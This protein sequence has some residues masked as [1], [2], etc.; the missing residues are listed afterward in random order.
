MSVEES[1][2]QYDSN[3]EEEDNKRKK[4][5]KKSK[6]KK[7]YSS[8]EENSNESND[9]ESKE[10]ESEENE[11]DEE[12]ESGDDEGYKKRKKKKKKK[13]SK[14]KK[15]KKSIINEKDE[16]IEEKEEIE[17]EKIRTK[18]DYIAQIEQLENE[19]LLEKKISD[20]LGENTEIN[21]ELLQLQTNLSE[22]TE[23]LNQLITTNH[24]QEEAL[25]VLRRQ[26]DK[27][28]DKYKSRN[29][30]KILL[31]QNFSNPIINNNLEKKRKIF[32]SQNDESKKEAINI[33]LKIK[34]KAI[35]VAINKMNM[36]KKENELLKKELYKNDDYTNKLGLEDNSNENKKKLLKLN[37][38]LK[39]LNSQLEEHQKCKY[40]RN[41][42]SK[43][44]LELKQNL[45]ELKQTIKETKDSLKEKQRESELNN[46]P[47]NIDTVE[48]ATTNNCLSPR[49]N[50]TK[51]IASPNS[52]KISRN[53]IPKLNLTK[54][55]KSILLPAILSPT[56]NKYD[57]NILS[58]EFY[59]KLKKHYEG[60][61]DEYEALLEKIK[62]TENSR[63]Y[64]INKHKNEIKQFNTQILS[65][66]EQFKILNNEG[67]GTGSN[68][69]VL[70]Y[71]LNI[72]KNEA[73]HCLSQL[74]KLK[75]KLDFAVNLSKERD[76]EIF[77]LKGQI[78]LIKNKNI[79]KKKK[80]SE[81]EK[82][83]ID[84]TESEKEKK[85]KKIE[86]KSIN[87]DNNKNKIVKNNK[88]DNIIKKENKNDSIKTDSIK[89]NGIKNDSIKNNNDEKSQ[90]MKRIINIKKA[91]T[92]AIPKT[93]NFRLNLRD[94]KK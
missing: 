38:E 61:E 46:I 64:I 78:N 49:S 59:S 92:S 39:I 75:N 29:R 62:E 4:N 7:K 87:K 36:Y 67:K 27:E 42:L 12:E 77:L 34:E 10:D 53:I 55:Y 68:I 19:L 58:D 63:N 79:I 23:K 43:E 66:D 80:E 89:N 33:V 81:T 6:K 44:Y 88:N 76:H 2:Q 31:A 84:S 41:L 35:N 28:Q 5:N 73:K 69:R 56:N 8:E 47:P 83:S 45:K 13:K 52:K 21:E 16:K 85:I 26:L 54:S 70:K 74:Q 32:L 86:R 3:E 25:S 18:D 20:S 57:K 90:N 24:R 40:E 50:I 60:R 9:E 91:L 17:E 30:P 65:L 93:N 48:D 94:K 15:R 51:T 71:K 14:K 72:T 1:S 11:D 22:K 82:D 37:D